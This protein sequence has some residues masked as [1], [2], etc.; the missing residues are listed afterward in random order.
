[1]SQYTFVRWLG[2]VVPV[3]ALSIAT[4]AHADARYRIVDL[5]GLGGGVSQGS[6]IN[7][8]GEILGDSSSSSTASDA[9]FAASNQRTG[10]A[11]FAQADGT[12]YAL[13]GAG[14][15]LNNRGEVAGT[16]SLDD[17]CGGSQR[18]A[19]V[20]SVRLGS[21]PLVPLA[22]DIESVATGIND[23]GAVVGYSADANSTPH[24]VVWINRLPQALGTPDGSSPIAINS[25]GQVLGFLAGKTKGTTFD[26]FLWTA[27]GGYQKAPS[28]TRL[29]DQ[30]SQATGFNDRGQILGT[31][32]DGQFVTHAVLW[33]ANM[34]LIDIGQAVGDTSSAPLSLNQRGEVLAVSTAAQGGTPHFFVWDGA[35]GMRAV[36][37]G[38][39][40]TGVS[41]LNDHDDLVGT[42]A[43]RSG[44][45]RAF[46]Y[47]GR[48][49][50]EL[51]TLG[52]DWSVGSAINASRDVAGFALDMT[53]NLHAFRWTERGHLENLGDLDSGAGNSVATGINR[54]GDVAGT[55]FKTRLTRHRAF[56]WSSRTHMSDIGSLEGPD[57]GF[58]EANGINSQG[59]VVGFSSQ[60][61][62][63]GNSAIPPF[64]WDAASG[65]RALPLPANF[66][67][68]ISAP[69]MA[70]NDRA[71][72]VGW[73]AAFSGDSGWIWDAQRGSRELLTA[74]GEGAIPTALNEQN[75]VVG[76]A[77]ALATSC[78]FETQRAFIA[79]DG[80]S[81]VDLG[82]LRGDAISTARGIN[83][84]GQVVGNS[85]S[86]TVR[87][88]LYD[89]GRMLDLTDLVSDRDWSLQSAEAINDAGEIT[90]VGLHR[91]H[92]HAFLLRP[93]P[94][95]DH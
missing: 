51:G 18:R 27:S 48:T 9:T 30:F 21:K 78:P 15:A 7:D 95:R 56:V 36:D 43:N 55:A 94:G 24:A 45:P 87:A 90:G 76:H 79:A 92:V 63:N 25:Q 49:L 68:F 93:L 77:Q 72:I 22:G 23:L 37:V 80:G 2:L 66:L 59:Q 69:A 32:T 5:G 60:N 4:S 1:M 17:A 73:G 35:R 84:R 83:A 3:A 86:P 38:Q 41:G 91:G 29:G 53:G 89:A 19:F 34:G 62:D 12:L 33:D 46:T 70:I 28:L 61:L 20:W 81:A 47:R 64:L 57:V 44:A 74:A 11:F 65:M 50:R 54:Q 39:A 67:T 16:Q 31:S 85:G 82:A 52:G 40:F 88:F 42:K 8:A 10:A 75:Q 14:V 13:P 71:T 6:A 26:F 58:T